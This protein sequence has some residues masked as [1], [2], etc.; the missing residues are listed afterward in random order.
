MEANVK[1]THPGVRE[2]HGTNSWRFDLKKSSPFE[3][4]RLL[5]GIWELFFFFFFKTQH[6][7]C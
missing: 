5:M 3:L 2:F 6:F 1:D 7:M 4:M